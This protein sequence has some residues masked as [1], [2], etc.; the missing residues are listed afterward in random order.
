MEVGM[1]TM[2]LHACCAPCLATALE[3]LRQGEPGALP[4]VGGIIFFNPNIHPLLEFRRRVKALRLYLERDPLQ[5]EIDDTYGLPAYLAAVLNADGSLPDR[6]ERCRRCYVHRLGKAAELAKGLG[7][8]AFSSTLLASREQDRELVAEAGAE[9][10]E[11]CGIEFVV[12]DLR[13]VLPPEKLM[14]G[15]YRQQYCGC[16]FSEEERYR[17]TNKHVYRPGGS[18][19]D[20]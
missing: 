8:G 16:I 12:A 9:A 5:A 20:D 10:G 19:D 3:T 1:D 17:N 4:G 15:I 18:G 14:R 13:K 2:A 6:R 11:V 7:Y